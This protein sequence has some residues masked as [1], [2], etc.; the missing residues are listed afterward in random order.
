MSAVTATATPA[1]TPPA[2]VALQRDDGPLA[3][4]LG[5]LAGG[6]PVTP[7][8][9]LLIAALPLAVVIAVRGTAASTAT[10]AMVVGWLVLVGGASSRPRADRL[11]WAEPPLLR[12][13]E[14][15]ALLWLG[16]LTPDGLPAAFALL[17]VLWFRHY[18]LVYRVRHQG[19][20]PPRRMGDLMGGWD[21]RLV[22]A[23]AVLAAGALPAAYYGYA[24]LIAAVLVGESVRSWR[25][26]RRAT[27]P[28]SY[29]EEEDEGQ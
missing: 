4:A 21:G 24:A 15:G 2:G 8:L 23:W 9:L 22:G 7:A 19:V 27:R 20:P 11:Q 1:P 13:A 18:D 17:C 6:L 28:I 10:A 3:R 14:Y 16:A 5:R 29:E 26:F 25:R 12:L